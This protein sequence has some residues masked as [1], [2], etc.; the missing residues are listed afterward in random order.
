MSAKSENQNIG[1]EMYSY[2]DMFYYKNVF[3]LKN[4]QHKHEL[5]Q[6]FE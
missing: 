4:N 5:L 3:Q 6:G 2:E 1:M